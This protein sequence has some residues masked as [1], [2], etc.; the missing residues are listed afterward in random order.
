MIGPYLLTLCPITRFWSTA[1]HS[2]DFTDALVSFL[3]NS[4]P[5]Y[6]SPDE[7]Y[8]A[9]ES[10]GHLYH[11]ILRTVLLILHRL[12]MDRESETEFMAEESLAETLYTNY[13]ITVPMLFDILVTYGKDN[14][15]VLQILFGRI[16]QLQP[17]YKYD[18]MASLEYIQRECLQSVQREIESSSKSLVELNDLIL[19]CLDSISILRMIV[20]VSPKIAVDA[21]LKLELEQDMTQ[22]YDTIVPLLYKN[23]VVFEGHEGAIENL[24]MIRVEILIC[25]RGIV[26]FHLDEMLKKK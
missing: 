10:A 14:L 20:E 23:V 21:F 13:I 25:F 17:K 18:L 22:F 12:T 5:C 19:F 6:M 1:V 4:N 2:K 15:G 26:N 7:L 9:D 24:K 11:R 3:Q 8:R 16:F